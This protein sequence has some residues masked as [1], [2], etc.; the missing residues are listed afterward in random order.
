MV[1]RIAVL[2]ILV[3]N[4]VVAAQPTSQIAALSRILAAIATQLDTLEKRAT[5]LRSAPNI[6]AEIEPR[7]R[8][9]L[10]DTA[11]NGDLALRRHHRQPMD[12]EGRTV[13]A[14]VAIES[15]DARPH[16]AAR[17]DGTRRATPADRGGCR[18]RRS[19]GATSAPARPS[20][21][22]RR[23]ATRQ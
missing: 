23:H 9:E 13:E 15:Y 2:L 3:L 1:V 21:R 19:G 8:E 6:H 11:T 4:A 17:H 22:W 16:V 14:E 20:T 18:G 12:V 5:E 10:F 7:A